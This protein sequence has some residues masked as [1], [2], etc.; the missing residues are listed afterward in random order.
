[1]AH[2]FAHRLDFCYIFV[3]GERMGRARRGLCDFPDL[4][5]EQFERVFLMYKK[6]LAGIVILALLAMTLAACSI[7][8]TSGPSGPTVHMGNANFTE[9]SITI[10]KG[11]SINLIDDVAVEHIITNGHWNNGQPDTAKESGAPS[12]NATFNGNDSNTLGPFTTSGTFHYY[13]TIHPGMDLTVV[14]Q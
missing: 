13:C 4:Y 5:L 6:L 8:D 12:Y 11:Q 7:H 10:S 2:Y 9:N 1:M 14:V 3:E